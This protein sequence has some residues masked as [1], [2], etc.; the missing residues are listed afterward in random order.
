MPLTPWIDVLGYRCVQCGG[1]ATHWYG[2]VTVCCQ[3]HGGDLVSQDEARRMH[4]GGRDDG[5]HGSLPADR[6]TPEW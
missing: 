4:E 3:C 1:F 2:H 5:A 6:A